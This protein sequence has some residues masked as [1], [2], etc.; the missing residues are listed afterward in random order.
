[1][2]SVGF[3][4]MVV[5]FI[6]ALVVLGPDKLPSAARQV[7][8]AYSEF[9]RVTSNFQD[10]IRGALDRDTHN[11]LEHAT[12]DDPASRMTEPG[13]DIPPPAD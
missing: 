11:D 4:E 9:K 6:V 2:G 3:P 8:R 5:V 13:A 1:V 7:G 10:D 12:A